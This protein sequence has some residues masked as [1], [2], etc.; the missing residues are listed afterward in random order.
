[1][2]RIKQGVNI[3][4]IK[5]EIVLAINIASVIFAK[6][7]VDCVITCGTN[8][9]HSRGSL[10]YVGYAVDLRSRDLTDI[11]KQNVLAEIKDALGAQFDI[12]LHSTHYHLEFQP[13]EKL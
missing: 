13:K 12:V 4:G 2:I 10:H 6:Y 1:M 11:S 7:K 8:G 5:Q 9:N 3:A